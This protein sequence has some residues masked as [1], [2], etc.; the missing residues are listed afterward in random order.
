MT[1]LTHKGVKFNWD[2][3]CEQAFQELKVRLTSA[4]LLMVPDRGV[5][6]TV[7]YDASREGLGCVLMHA[8]GQSRIEL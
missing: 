2:E 1:R 8:T 7:Y 3:T 4:P 5:D 6:Y